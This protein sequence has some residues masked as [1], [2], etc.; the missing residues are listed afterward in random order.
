MDCVWDLLLQ[1]D[2]WRNGFVCLFKCHIF[3]FDF[4]PEISSEM[5]MVPLK[6]PTLIWH[7]KRQFHVVQKFL[8][9]AFKGPTSGMRTN[10]NLNGKPVI[11]IHNP[12]TG[13]RSLEYLFKVRR[14][15]HSFPSAKLTE[16]HWLSHYVISSVR[17][18]FDRYVSWYL[19]LVKNRKRNSLSKKH[20]DGIFEL[21]PFEFWDLIQPLDEFSSLQ[22]N[23]T[24]FPSSEKPQ[25]DLV[26]RFE[27]ISKWV[28]ILRDAGLIDLGESL[29]HIGLSTPAK[30]NNV[31]TLN[32]KDSEVDSLRAKIEE[33][34][35]SD[36]VHFGYKFGT[37]Y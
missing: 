23:W 1:I 37:L 12:R 36:Y 20:G 25:A 28:G 5:V 21:D 16:E 13:G 14:L 32:L 15:S 17:H 33:H 9:G 27:E 24:T 22:Q 35:A 3:V 18:P 7:A 30:K 11:F 2:D 31:E 8:G 34:F 29:P 6:Q 10:L 26:L 4:R 19:G